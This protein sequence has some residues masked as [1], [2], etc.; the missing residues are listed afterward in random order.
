VNEGGPETVEEDATGVVGIVDGVWDTSGLACP[1][2]GVITRVNEDGS[3]TMGKDTTGVVGITGGV[4]DT[5]G[6]DTSSGLGMKVG[7]RYLCETRTAPAT[8]ATTIMMMTTTFGFI[9]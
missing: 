1:S 7:C 2:T 9:R 5:S 8:K 4:W 3:E 6:V